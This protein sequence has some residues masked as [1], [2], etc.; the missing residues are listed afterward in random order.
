MINKQEAILDLENYD[1]IDIGGTSDAIPGPPPEHEYLR[2][3]EGR[4]GQPAEAT[5]LQGDHG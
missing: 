4:Y 3:L 2:F 5:D 1:E